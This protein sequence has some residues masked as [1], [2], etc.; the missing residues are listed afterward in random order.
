MKKDYKIF[1]FIIF[2]IYL[3]SFFIDKIL[4]V[5][6]VDS[7]I[8]GLDFKIM[9][10][11]NNGE[12]VMKGRNIFKFSIKNNAEKIIKKPVKIKKIVKIPEIKPVHVIKKGNYR[13]LILSAIYI[14]GN[15]KKAVFLFND[16]IYTLPENGEF[17]HFK[18]L[19]IFKTE[20]ELMDIDSRTTKK[21][22]VK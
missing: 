22:S 12:I 11:H 10:P 19:H 7:N 3:L 18:V 2:T 6:S 15:E 8:K 14:K 16:K 13:G 17:E 1:I 9:L 20:V 21:M 4:K 5:N